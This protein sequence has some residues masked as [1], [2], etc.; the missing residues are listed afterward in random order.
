MDARTKPSRCSPRLARSSPGLRRRPSSSGWTRSPRR[1]FEALGREARPPDR[2]RAAVLE[3]AP[4]ALRQRRP[5]C[6]LRD[7]R[8]LHR[9]FSVPYAAWKPDMVA[10]TK[11]LP[12]FFGFTLKTTWPSL[13]VFLA[14]ARMP[15][16]VSFTLAPESRL[17]WAFMTETRTVLM[18]FG[19]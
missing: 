17:P 14:T 16:P 4:E 11:S 5:D 9:T 12:F 19:R 6:R 2:N 10:A 13:S 18:R 8:R 15:T 3:H 7:G 1:P